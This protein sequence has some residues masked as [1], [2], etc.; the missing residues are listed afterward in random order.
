MRKRMEEERTKYK[1]TVKRVNETASNSLQAGLIPIF[2]A[3]ENFTSETLQAYEH[4]RWDPQRK[5]PMHTDQ[6]QCNWAFN[7]NAA[8]LSPE[9]LLHANQHI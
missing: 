2:E 6:K 9:P 1:E 7:K 4:V 8:K 5:E 3:L